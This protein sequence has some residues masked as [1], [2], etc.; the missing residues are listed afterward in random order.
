VTGF[1]VVVVVVVDGRP[2][3]PPRPRVIMLEVV[4]V[5]DADEYGVD[6]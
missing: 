2:P 6:A 1:V 5:A 3:P 4:G